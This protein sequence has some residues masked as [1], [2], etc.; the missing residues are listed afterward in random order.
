MNGS[1]V[2]AALLLAAGFVLPY[3]H[4]APVEMEAPGRA[5]TGESGLTG[6]DASALAKTGAPGLAGTDASPLAGTGAHGR[7]ETNS[8]EWVNP[9]PTICS[10]S[11]I[12]WKS[13][14]GFGLI[15]GHA[16]TLMKYEP[17][18]G[19]K[20]TLL[21]TTVQ[22]N[23]NAVAYQPAGATAL[24]VGDSGM[25]QR[26][27]G[28]SFQALASG[29]ARSLHDVVWEPDGSAALLIGDGGTVLVYKGSSISALPNQTSLRLQAG[30]WAP[31]K[32]YALLVGEK[33]VACRA[34]L[35][36]YSVLATGTTQNL[37]DVAYKPDGSSATVVGN[38]GTVLVYDGQTFSAGPF[39]ANQNFY[40]AAWKPD[41]TGALVVGGESG[42]GRASAFL[43]DGSGLSAL[44]SGIQVN[45][46]DVLW[47]PGS[48]SALI[49][50]SRGLVA[51][52]DSGS[53]DI[54]S[55]GVSNTMNVVKWRPDGSYALVAGTSGYLAKYDGTALSQIPSGTS[56]ELDGIAWHP[57]MD[58]A[59]VCGRDGTVLRYDHATSSVTP[60][61]DGLV[62]AQNYSAAN[63]KPDGSYALLVGRDGRVV[64]FNGTGFEVQQSIF[65]IDY[66]DV[67]W[68][69]DGAYALI[70]AVSG[71]LLKYEE[72]ALPPPLDFCMT[73]VEGAPS[74]NFFSVSWY[75]D[76]SVTDALVAGMFGS[77]AVLMRFNDSGLTSLQTDLKASLFGVD[78][79]PGS[80]CALAAGSGGRL[81]QFVRYGFI[82]PPSGTDSDITFMDV[83]WRP[84]GACALAAGQSG[85]LLKFTWDK[86]ASPTAIISS[87]RMN[88]VFEP[89][90]TILFDGS[91]STPTFDDTLLFHWE[92]NLSGALGDGPKL[93]LVLPP[94]N[95]LI[96]LYANDTRGHS[97]TAS[98]SIRVKAPNRAPVVM[99]DSPQDGAVYNNTDEIAFDATRSY[100]PDGDQFSFYWTSSRSG[101]LGSSPAFSAM[102]P[103]GAHTINLWLNDSM[104]Y[105]VSKSVG[106]TVVPFNRP[107]SA[108]MTSPTAGGSYTDKDPV[109]FD[110]R[111]SSDPDGDALDFYWTSNVTG[112]LGSAQR[113]TRTLPAG[114]HQI[115]VWADDAMGGNRSASA[116]IT[117][118]KANE[119]PTVSVDYPAEGA[120]LSG[121]VEFS[122]VA[123]D[124]EGASVSVSVQ[125]DVSDW[126]PASGG[127]AWNFSLDTTTLANGRHA[128]R[129]KA[130]DGQLDS[131]EI[132]RNVTVHN[133]LWGWT[134]S[135]GIPLDGAKVSGRL[136]IEGAASRI[137]S[138]VTQVELRIDGGDWVVVG[139]T[140][141][142]T[143][144]LDT[145]KLRNGMHRV[146][147]RAY[148]GTDYSGEAGISLKVDNHPAAAASSPPYLLLLL[149]MIVIALVVAVA[150][151][152][153]RGKPRK[154][155]AAAVKEEEEEE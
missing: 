68:K 64:K 26:Y 94:G 45:L 137:G 44:A 96:T 18:A 14:N 142:W 126:L 100:D 76:P 110:A 24:I 73:R 147:V 144:M 85:A 130:S 4:G 104:G 61:D 123:L 81:L 101:F 86:A 154:P 63:W 50:G 51:E 31:G 40:A 23:L 148:D 102:L 83:A 22:D 111:A 153:A 89:G 17:S 29:T 47:E 107:P 58:Y 139:G 135:I 55:S 120:V 140:S 109:L 9:A 28:A 59:L 132:E 78:W 48:T 95:H 87:P 84:D 118:L 151:M 2:I 1:T 77:S 92:S 155:E 54:L 88:A 43:L 114:M 34:N 99:M 152:A 16:G 121:T 136:D 25:V 7:A 41:G 33:G 36:D 13:G 106:I 91:N 105:N 66:W 72:R 75:R 20:F 74:A 115:T 141:S 5:V 10:L 39:A 57:S 150:A 143:F 3:A 127:R 117:V 11:G 113:F 35:T 42:T 93:P 27:D 65:T 37:Y 12:A 129:V 119:P 82:Q 80:G 98:V 8:L 138:S 125:L 103:L 21:Q 56:S 133:P 97:A 116:N 124:P 122:G 79:L 38:S 60:L 69:P 67:A 15:A 6:T 49:V 19:Q 62:V 53:F 108:V 145:T 112:Y 128:I 146:T 71:N 90:A 30:A 131:P 70:A 52:Y 134:V 149:A 32:D 46:H